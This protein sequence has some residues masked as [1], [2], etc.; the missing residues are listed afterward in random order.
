MR[1]F[2]ILI[3]IFFMIQIFITD[4]NNC[5]GIFPTIIDSDNNP[6]N[7]T[8][9]FYKD[10]LSS[11]MSL[12]KNDNEDWYKI[13]VE[14]GD[15]FSVNLT[16]PETGDYDFELYDDALD[17]IVGSYGNGTY[18]EITISVS[19][20]GYCYIKLIA[21]WGNG[22]Y[23]LR[24]EYLGDTA[25]GNDDIFNATAINLGDVITDT[26]SS[27]NQDF[28]DWY[29]FNASMG[30]IIRVNLTLPETADFDFEIFNKHNS[31]IGGSAG[32]NIY[33][34]DIFLSTYDDFY[35]LRLYVCSG[36]GSYTLRVEKIGSYEM[37]NND[38]FINS[39]PINLDEPV[40]GRFYSH[41]DT[42]DCYKV[43]ATLGDILF[44]NFTS[45]DLELEVIEL[46][47]PDLQNI[48]SFLPDGLGWFDEYRFI[49]TKDG[50]HYIKLEI[51]HGKGN[52]SIEVNSTRPVHVEKFPH[53]IQNNITEY[54]I[55]DF[56]Q[57]D[58][59]INDFLN[60]NLEYNSSC[61]L[62]LYLFDPVGEIVAFS[63][64]FTSPDRI[65]LTANTSGRYII[66]ILP[67]WRFGNY[68]FSVDLVR[69]NS[70]PEITNFTPT[71]DISINEGEYITF[72]VTAF[73][74]QNDS[75][76]YIWK[77]DGIKLL[78]T[79]D[80]SLTI[81]TTFNDDYSAGIYQIALEV[82]DGKLSAPPLKWT[83]KVTNVNIGPEIITVTPYSKE[84]SINETESFIFWV[85]VHDPDPAPP[86][87]K[88][89]RNGIEENGTT[90]NSYKFTSN[91]EMAGT[92]NV[93]VEVVDGENPT[94]V[95]S[96]YWIVS[97]SN[98][99]RKPII[100]SVDP[101]G[102]VKI[103]EETSINFTINATDPDGDL[104]SF[105]WYFDAIKMNESTGNNLTFVPNYNSSDGKIHSIQVVIAS[106]GLEVSYIWELNIVDIN[107]FPIINN[108]TL[109]PNK[110]VKLMAG[111]SI[112]FSIDAF[113]PDGDNITYQWI[114]LGNN[115][116]IIS[117]NQSFTYT[118]DQ[119]IYR[120]LV[121]SNDTKGGID[122]LEFEI[123]VDEKVEESDSDGNLTIT[124][125]I[126]TLIVI[127][128]GIIG[129]TMVRKKNS[130]D[131]LKKRIVKNGENKITSEKD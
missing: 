4:Y 50:F 2:V 53:N 35:Y 24:V 14:N 92:Y 27:A 127:I 16:V 3:F 1:K 71:G 106:N 115:E 107:R 118:F 67:M 55:S 37:E 99:D 83:L 108:S 21:S 116:I 98:K 125:T 63:D 11:N 47:D 131:W 68:T 113:D 73:D 128:L 88:W 86:I 36:N 129:W 13:F 81:N 69:F 29:K 8:E 89:F 119:G 31:W 9:I 112:D 74:P 19:F 77:V 72:N 10:S 97:V 110:D 45:N 26:L 90:G 123:S 56:Y 25:D 5:K 126:I 64:N 30:D 114:L 49:V 85:N 62:D 66:Q 65:F 109:N 20:T 23:I 51:S 54:E 58:A 84:I 41:F 96:C 48:T 121:K 100:S 94:M 105:T 91:Y 46:L 102:N 75:L 40:V 38:D 60:L 120:I 43:N 22:T 18:E 12:E 82:N 59:G 32:M 28:N 7:S 101:P 80:D 103:N 39:T 79:H 122:I 76:A 61:N 130:N 117:N 52:Y 70:P 15:V 17:Y 93:S 95:E 124:I 6:S 57:L 42:I 33:E 44:L 111:E 104:L 78:N 34:E 87:F